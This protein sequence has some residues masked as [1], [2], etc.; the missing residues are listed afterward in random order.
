MKNKV[1]LHLT[2]PEEYPEFT[3]RAARAVTRA[4][5]GN[6]IQFTSLRIFPTN[7]SNVKDIG[8]ASD[9]GSRPMPDANYLL[10]EID[11]TI[12][13]Y[14]DYF[15]LG[16]VLWPVYPTL[17]AGNF[18]ELVDKCVEKGLY[19]YDFWGYVPGSKPSNGIW[20]E[21]GIPEETDAC[22]REKL[23]EHF[24]GYD[25]GEQDGRYIH[26][27]AETS[28]PTIDSRVMQYRNF[29]AYFEKLNDAMQNHTVTLSSLTYLH[30]FAREG[31]TI[32]LGAET[33][34]A[35]PSNPMWFSFI[36][37]ASKQYGLLNYGNA[38]VWNRWGYKDYHIA[39]EQPDTSKGYEAGRT[40]GTSLS[41]LRR[42]IYNQYMYNC[43]ILGFEG[44]WFTTSEASDGD[45]NDESHYI[46]GRK[47]YTLTPVGVIARRC[48]EFV[49]E[50]GFPGT[51]YTPVAIIA[52]F[53]CG[54]MPPR[55]LYSPA[56]YR[57]WG[58]LP[59]S[60]GDY[61]LHALFSM[62]F[63][64]YENSGFYRDERGFLT[65]TPY[66]EC[67][68][69]L[70]SD[71]RAEILARYDTA[72]LLSGT[73]IDIELLHKLRS[74]T[75]GGGKLLVFAGALDSA[76]DGAKADASFA[77]LF[78]GCCANVK[79]LDADSLERTDDELNFR[80][81]VN[82]DIARPYRFKAETAAALD[83][84]LSDV[85]LIWADNPALQYT[86]CVKDEENYTL[87]VANNTLAEERF[88]IAACR[89]EIV[90]AEAEPIGDG[91]ES[92]PEFMPRAEFVHYTEPVRTSGKYTL[93]PYDCRI[94]N[95]RAKGISFETLPKS[96]PSPRDD[97]LYLS[98]GYENQSA[99]NYLLAHP[100]FAHHFGGMLLPAEYLDR[101]GTEAA[102]REAHYFK[103]QNVKIIVDFTRMINHYPDL[104]IIGNFPART[105][106]S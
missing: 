106:A 1:Y 97:R 91:V 61:A 46:V 44:G 73:E 96:N 100:T 20:G 90:S 82:E 47:K 59:Y 22:L 75:D 105:A 84:A 65:P 2:E 67:A 81:N 34:Q 25:N 6:T 36:R 103:L 89:G 11:E 98:L 71:V 35:L 53:G 72:I 32:M 94:Y 16:R 79:I 7:S 66:G 17:F 14:V 13:L 86:L 102:E 45:I 37:G 43:D 62:L 4:A 48:G 38:S 74:F 63:P 23:G 3:R 30:Y 70:L 78:G 24:L 85:R 28:V 10:R 104:T 29:Q 56:V 52:G 5:L 8:E 58:N 64:G 95:V 80:N 77:A 68:D 92:L 9:T 93:K 57:V 18:K 69:V 55:Q 60:E 21:Y 15:K 51:L 88:N 27:S 49:L 83:S 19:L 50:H 33:A 31:N 87:F 99:K 41:L 26:A 42:L 40:A 54:W 39:S 101:L 76:T 12:E